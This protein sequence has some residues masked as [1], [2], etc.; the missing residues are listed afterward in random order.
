MV[1]FGTGQNL[2]A[3]LISSRRDD[4]DGKEETARVHTEALIMEE[5]MSEALGQLVLLTGLLLVRIDA[6]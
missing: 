6:Q 1:F 3:Q 5:R 2:V 4:A